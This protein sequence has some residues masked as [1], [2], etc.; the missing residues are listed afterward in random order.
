MSTIKGSSVSLIV[1]VTH[2][3]AVRDVRLPSETRVSLRFWRVTLPQTS[4]EP[5][6]SSIETNYNLSPIGLYGLHV[7]LE[8]GSAR[9]QGI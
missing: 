1:K 7:S 2:M 3:G 6:K 9:C 5:Q 4:T 8:E